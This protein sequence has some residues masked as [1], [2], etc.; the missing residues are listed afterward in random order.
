MKTWFTAVLLIFVCTNLSASGRIISSDSDSTVKANG[1]AEKTRLK[2][3]QLLQI[4]NYEQNVIG[5]TFETD[6][7]PF[8]DFTFSASTHVFPFNYLI[9]LIPEPKRP[10]LSLRFAFTAR[11]GQYIGTRYSNPVIEK[12]F[13]PYLFL[14]YSPKKKFRRSY[15]QLGYGHESNGQVIDD[16][17]TFFEVA[18]LP[19]NDVD[20]TKDNISRGWDYIASTLIV[21][22]F[23][24]DRQRYIIE[25]GVALKYYLNK[26]LLQGPKEEYHSWET[27]V[28]PKL[29]R[30]KVNG[31]SLVATCHIDSSYLN[32][33]QLTYETGI[34]SPLHHSTIKLLAGFKFGNFPFAVFY[35]YGYNGDLAQY[36]KVNGSL[37]IT[38]IIP[39]FES[40]DNKQK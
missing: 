39:S 9:N 21:N 18:S 16:S 33:I 6:D 20:N 3:F 35:R 22:F 37:G 15:V 26:G 1:K 25:A 23:P 32:K 19:H 5:Y 40:Y 13:N 30:N 36:G 28:D 8:L 10:N 31:I 27:W 29:T 11:F 4:Q 2:V 34:W 7:E 38:I 14:Q 12:R 24:K 17:L